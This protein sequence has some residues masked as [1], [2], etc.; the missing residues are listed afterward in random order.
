MN[1][2][3]LDDA[4]N[5]AEYYDSR[6]DADHQ[7]LLRHQLER[8]LT[9]RF[10]DKY[11][12]PKGKLLEIGSATG[13]YTIEL[14]RRGYQVTGVDFSKK[15][16]E[17]C[18]ES[19]RDEGLD[20]I[21]RLVVSDAR[22]LS[23]L[24]DE[25]FDSIL[26]MG[27]FYHLVEESDRI[28][29]LQNAIQRLRPNGLIISAFISRLGVLAD[30]LN[31]SPEWIEDQ[32]YVRS[33]LAHGRRPRD[34]GKGGFRGFFAC[35]DEIASFNESFGFV[36]L[37]LAGVEPIIA[38]HDEDFN[39]LDCK[40]REKW[41]DLMFEISTEKSIFGASRHILYIGKKDG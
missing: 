39:R 16:I 31:R 17:K 5:I 33:F 11:L 35:P 22:Y 9:L 37:V 3:I 20:S 14:A 24:G 10:L 36:T 7:R 28:L 27:P 19:L 38:A 12:P 8:E 30:L 18:A 4:Q 40:Q 32:K 26:I 1:R 6:P 13:R 21:V 25:T 34:R 29:A 2:K 41:L 15:L 23:E